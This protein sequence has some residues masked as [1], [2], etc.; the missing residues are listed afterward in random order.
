MIWEA[1][2]VGLTRA[3]VW[4]RRSRTLSRIPYL[5]RVFPSRRRPLTRT[6]FYADHPEILEVQR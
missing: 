5:A 6:W 1:T 3:E 4:S 2:P